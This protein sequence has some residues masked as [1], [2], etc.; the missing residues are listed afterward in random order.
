MNDEFDPFV[1]EWKSYAKNP[2]LNLIEKCL[3]L[4][5]IIEIKI[6]QLDLKRF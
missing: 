1:A 5:Q 2:K 4:A 3:K 6:H